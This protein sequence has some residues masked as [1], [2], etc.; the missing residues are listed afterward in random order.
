MSEKPRLSGQQAFNRVFWDPRLN[1]DAF[2][3]GH[4]DRK[5]AGGVCE[6]PLVH[7]DPEGYIP[8]HRILYIRCGSEVVWSRQGAVDRLSVGDLPAEAWLP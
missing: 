6:V 3:I 7:W 4:A 8:W 2:V 1:R 5:A